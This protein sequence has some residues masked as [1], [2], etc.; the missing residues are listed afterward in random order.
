M[1]LVSVTEALNIDK[2]QGL[3]VSLHFCVGKRGACSVYTCPCF[4]IVI[5]TNGT[6][7]HYTGVRGP[8]T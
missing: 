3:M 1:L 2:H 8:P 7:L 4:I 6:L 5:V